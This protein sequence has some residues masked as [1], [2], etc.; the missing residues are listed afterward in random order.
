[1]LCPGLLIPRSAVSLL[2]VIGRRRDAASR[3]PGCSFPICEVEMLIKLAMM[4]KQGDL[5]SSSLVSGQKEA[6]LN[7]SSCHW[8]CCH[9]VAK[10][11]FWVCFFT[12]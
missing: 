5:K 9:Y 11:L 12:Y 3:S 8:Y 1:M 10:A 4:Y 7:W 6:L 2:Y